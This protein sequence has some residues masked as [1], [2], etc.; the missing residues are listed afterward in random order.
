MNLGSC[1]LNGIF[2]E[3]VLQLQSLQTLDLALNKNLSGSLP[4]FP[5]NGALRSLVLSNTN[6]SGTI[7]DSI[8]N[9]KNL[10][11]IE[12]PTSN[13]SGRIPKSMENLTQLS[14]LDLSSN[15]LTGQIPS[16]QQCKNLTHIDLS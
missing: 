16:F 1:N 5:I 8:G 4:D 3:N 14:Y 10:S 13:F 9:L 2:L 6:F 7:P 12:L 11:R 15:K